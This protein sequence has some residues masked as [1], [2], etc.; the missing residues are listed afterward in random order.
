MAPVD[1]LLGFLRRAVHDFRSYSYQNPFTPVFLVFL[2]TFLAIQIWI[3]VNYSNKFSN[4]F[5]AQYRADIGL[6]L[7][8]FS[9]GSFFH[10]GTNIGLLLLFM[11][12]SESKMTK[13][14][15]IFFV[16]TV[17]YV[18]TYSQVLVS[19]YTTGTAGTLGVSGVAYAFLPFYAIIGY[20]EVREKESKVTSHPLI[21]SA[22]VISL[23]MPFEMAGL[24]KLGL[25]SSAEPATITH[26]V[27]FICGV[28]Y[29]V[30]R[31]I[32]R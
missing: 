13:R 24:L 28:L 21:L 32:S 10:I 2:L 31:S 22:I 8:P 14:E 11:W 25:N 23:T 27:G 18:S 29:G 1:H 4:L 6:I 20:T 16:V 30:Y 12:P 26:A 17:A 7:A 19:G 3:A 5:V 9:H 15:L